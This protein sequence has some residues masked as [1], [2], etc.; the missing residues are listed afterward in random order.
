MQCNAE[1]SSRLGLLVHTVRSHCLFY[2]FLPFDW[3]FVAGKLIWFYAKKLSSNVLST[4]LSRKMS[5]MLKRMNRVSL[6][7]RVIERL[8][9]LTMGQ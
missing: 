5:E 8:W 2:V 1:E 3:L 4:F 7:E 9:I 6:S